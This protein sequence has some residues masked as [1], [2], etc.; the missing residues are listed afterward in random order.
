MV[1][2]KSLSDSTQMIQTLKTPTIG[3]LTGPT[4]TGKSSLALEL[5]THH[6]NIEIINADSLLVYRGMNIGTAKPTPQE[7]AQVPHHLID[8]R[9][10]N[11][12]FTAGE[13]CRAAEAAIQAI[14]NKGK[15]VLIVGG[16]G[17]YLKSLL[18]GLWDAPAAD[19]NFR[20]ELDEKTN[21][22]LFRELE[23]R[24]PPSA[25]RIGQS[26]R[27][28]L[29]RALEIIHLTGRSPTELQSHVKKEADPRFKLWIID[30]STSELTQRIE[31]RTQAMLHQGLIEEFKSL[32]LQFP[33][34]RSLESIGYKQVAHYLAARQPPGRKVKSGL[35]GLSDEIQLATRQLVKSQRTWFRNQSLHVSSSIWFNLDSECSKL[36]EA[37]K[38]MYL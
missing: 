15:R 38:S 12:S 14:Q 32:Q 30:R 16:T 20:K 5:A 11:E 3:I 24:D 27:Y 23:Q 33:G 29:V 37:F 18:F 17:F 31:Q 6:R 25:L 8:I 2:E 9:D 26:D 36:E 1:S 34:S 19:L 4:A 13:F 35:E 21:P 10:P 7:L 28:R 22:Q